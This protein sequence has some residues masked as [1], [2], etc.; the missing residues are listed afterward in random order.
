VAK[1][2]TSV[3]IVGGGFAGVHAARRLSKQ[4]GV[5]VTL[6][7][8]QPNFI[9]YPQLYHAATGG[10]RAEASQSLADILKGERVRIVKDKIVGLDKQ[11][12]TVTG[13]S[14]KEYDYDHLVLALGSVTNYFGIKGLKE[15]AYDIKSID[16]A[17][18]F[19]L[20]LHHELVELRKPELNYVVIGAGPTG[21]ELSAALGQYLRRIVKLHDIV[22]PTYTIDLIEAAPRILPHSSERY[23]AKVAKRLERLGVKIMVGTAVQAETAEGLEIQGK[24]LESHTVVWTSGV[25][26]NPF[27]ATNAKS[28]NLAKN[29][30]VVVNDHM[31]AAE[32]IY[33]IG[34]NAASQY[35]GLAE[36]AVN[37]AD[38]VA[39]DI[40]RR[41]RGRSRP[42]YKQKPPSS[43]IPVGSGWA[44]AQLGPVAIYGYSGWL[45]RRL[46]DLIAYR[47]IEP[48]TK[49]LRVW[50]HEGRHEDDCALCGS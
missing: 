7:S 23:A 38:F 45:I 22:E 33:V 46:A 18:A 11:G 41:L 34:D 32:N 21:V 47:T 5:E 16:G 31:E 26:N 35:G 39:S 42:V 20:H 25:A 6:I 40:Q 1:T 3:V 17:E 12:R 24:T 37:D 14:G 15:F 9:Y 36:T 28:F 27:F 50:L 19:K 13:E 48:T 30:R 49:A 10:M 44:A 2:K 8:D 43:V 4:R 29:G